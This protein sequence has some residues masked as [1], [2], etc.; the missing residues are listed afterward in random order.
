MNSP[1]PEGQGLDNI[2]LLRA[3]AH[4]HRGRTVSCCGE[5]EH[6]LLLEDLEHDSRNDPD[7]AALLDRASALIDGPPAE[8][9]WW[10]R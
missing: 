4:A 6:E 8:V 1:R 3:L 9:P 10:A 2:I 7:I 5:A